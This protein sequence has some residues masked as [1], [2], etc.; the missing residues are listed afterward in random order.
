MFASGPDG[1]PLRVAA[2]A[3]VLSHSLP[4][5]PTLNPISA[6]PLELLSHFPL[7]KPATESHLRVAGLAIEAG[8]YMVA[9]RDQQIND[10]RLEES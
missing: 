4:R 5:K 2:L 1:T 3:I 7:L 10:R 8:R 9:Q 6:S